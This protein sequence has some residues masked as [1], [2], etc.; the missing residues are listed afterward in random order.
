MLHFCSEA[1]VQVYKR[2]IALEA[3]EDILNILT[4]KLET[5]KTHKDL[6]KI[7][8]QKVIFTQILLFKALMAEKPKAELH[9]LYDLIKDQLVDILTLIG[10]NRS[11]NTMLIFAERMKGMNEIVPPMIDVLGS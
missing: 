5:I 9:R 2:E 10:D 11:E 7:P 1:C 8:A 3:V 4:E 6:F